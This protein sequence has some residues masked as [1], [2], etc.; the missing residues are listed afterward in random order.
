M[1]SHLRNH[2]LKSVL[3]SKTKLFIIFITLSQQKLHMLRKSK[4]VLL[5][6]PRNMVSEIQST[7]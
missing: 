5:H 7:C 2:V 4:S 1:S 3:I 6:V